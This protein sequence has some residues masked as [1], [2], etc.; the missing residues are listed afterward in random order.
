MDVDNHNCIVSIDD[1]IE[2]IGR[3]EVR[4]HL[5]RNI[6]LKR[7]WECDHGKKICCLAN[8]HEIP[9]A[10]LIVGVENNGVLSGKDD[11]WLSTKE[12]NISQH[13]NINLDPAQACAGLF[14]HKF[15]AGCVIIIKVNSPGDVVYWNKKAYKGIGTSIKEMEPDEIIKL[16]MSL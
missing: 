11:K 9:C 4:E 16:R 3:C 2:R 8:K 6:E 10:W 1:L 13:I 7:D 5:Y 12:E 14:T 15:S